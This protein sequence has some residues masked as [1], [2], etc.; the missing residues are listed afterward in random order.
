[1]ACIDLCTDHV[2]ALLLGIIVSTIRIQQP[3]HS[4]AGVSKPDKIAERC[5][6]VCCSPMVVALAC[7]I[8][9]SA[10]PA[11]LCKKDDMGDAKLGVDLVPERR[12][13]SI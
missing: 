10:R 9:S 4:Q 8:P 11:S 5:G 13:S 12:R 3:W 2:I 7:R 1:M 6:T